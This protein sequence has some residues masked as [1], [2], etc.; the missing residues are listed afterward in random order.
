MTSEETSIEYSNYSYESSS[1]LSTDESIE[2]TEITEI[3]NQTPKILHQTW[4]SKDLLPKF[5]EWQK[6]WLDMCPD[7]KYK[8]YTDEHLIQVFKNHL[9][10]YLESFK[11]F[12]KQIERVDF[13]RYAI[14]YVYGGVYADMDVF[15]LKSIDCWLEKNKIILGKEPLEHSRIYDG[16][17]FMICNAFM[18]SPKGEKFW[19]E[20]MDFIIANYSPDSS[21]V[22]TTGPGIITNFYYK[23]PEKFCNVIITE[24]ECFFPLTAG[25]TN[26]FQIYKGKV[27]K[28]VSKFCNVK[29]AFVVH[30]WEGTWAQ[31]PS[32]GITLIGYGFVIIILIL[33]LFS[34]AI[35]M[36][37]TN[38]SN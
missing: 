11:S 36:G 26:K 18:I 5:I 25:K 9:P 13:W 35:G 24:P 22:R 20:L 19:L 38:Y 7:Y 23:H 10:Q 6:M 31:L 4:K 17:D 37:Y 15:P 8:F 1:S 29:K 27:F 33:I 12:A 28:N 32:W 21:P 2:I 30:M 16:T 14:L 3:N 34:F